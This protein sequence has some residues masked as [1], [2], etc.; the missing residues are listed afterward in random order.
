VF[1]NRVLRRILE[2]KKDEVIGSWRKLHNEEPHN[3]CSSSS[4]IRMVKS[5]GDEMVQHVACKGRRGLRIRFWQETQEERDHLEDLDAGG[6]ILIRLIL[7]RVDGVVWT[8]LISL[9]IGTSGE[10]L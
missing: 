2:S 8:G 10:L 4:I 7:E 6:M 9:K 1:K 3:L 5:R